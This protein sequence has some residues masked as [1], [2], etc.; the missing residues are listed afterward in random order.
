MAYKVLI[1]EL[2]TG[3]VYNTKLELFLGI[4]ETLSYFDH[5]EEAI[6]YSDS[7]VNNNPALEC[8]IKDE[9]DIILRYKSINEE[10][11]FD[12]H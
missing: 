12:L 1:A 7:I 6:N 11:L 2:N 4:G 8:W 9:K 3:H 10:K 5:Y